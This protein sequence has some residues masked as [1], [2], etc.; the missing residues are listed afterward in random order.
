MSLTKTFPSVKKRSA[1]NG[2]KNSTEAGATVI[3]KTKTSGSSFPQKIAKLNK[4]LAKA[5]LIK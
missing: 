5:K 4:L 3:F 1:T 2:S